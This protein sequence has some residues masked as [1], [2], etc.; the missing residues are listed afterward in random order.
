MGSSKR[1]DTNTA[2]NCLWLC[3]ECHNWAESNRTA[4]LLEGVLV[5][6]IDCPAKAAVRY[7]GVQVFLDDNGNLEA[8]G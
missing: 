7:R 5:L 2:A 3:L 6:Q 4:A 8:V 1:P